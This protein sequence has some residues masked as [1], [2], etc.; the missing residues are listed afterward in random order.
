MSVAGVI[1]AVLVLIELQPIIISIYEMITKEKVAQKNVKGVALGVC[2]T[3]IQDATD[4]Y[5]GKRK[6]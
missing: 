1:F 4:I 5:E 3:T 2:R 6:K